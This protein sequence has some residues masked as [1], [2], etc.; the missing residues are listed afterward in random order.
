M[1][2]STQRFWQDTYERINELRR[3]LG[4]LPYINMVDAVVRGWLLL[5]EQQQKTVMMAF[6]RPDNCKPRGI[7]LWTCTF[8]LLALAGKQNAIFS[9][10]DVVEQFHMMVSGWELL[11]DQQKTEALAA[12][13]GPVPDEPLN[14]VA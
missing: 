10:F 13:G 9:K 1:Y 3:P 11:T 7:G 8:K 4:Q 6:Q 12:V 5:N 14:H 2:P